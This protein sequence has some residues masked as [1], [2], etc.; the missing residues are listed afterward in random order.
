MSVITGLKNIDYQ[1]FVVV[2]ILDALGIDIDTEDGHLY[3]SEDPTISIDIGGKILRVDVGKA[4]KN[5]DYAIF[6]PLYREDHAQFLM[7]LAIYSQV[8]EDLLDPDEAGAD[9]FN[10]NTDMVFPV[11]DGQTVMIPHTLAKVAKGDGSE[12]FGEAMHKEETFAI[13]LAILE[14]AYKTKL[15]SSEQATKLKSEIDQAYQDYLVTSEMKASQRRKSIKEKEALLQ[16]EV[17]YDDQMFY[18]DDLTPEDEIN[19]EKEELYFDNN[20]EEYRMPAMTDSDFTDTQPVDKESDVFEEDFTDD[21]LIELFGIFG[22][23]PP[24]PE[25]QIDEITVD[26]PVQPAK[27]FDDIQFSEEVSDAPIYPVG[28]T[29]AENFYDPM[30][31]YGCPVTNQNYPI[32]NPIPPAEVE[33]SANPMPD[34]QLSDIVSKEDMEAINKRNEVT[35]STPEDFINHS[36]YNMNMMGS[37]GFGNTYGYDNGGFVPYIPS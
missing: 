7:T 36:D 12:I 21:E 23:T 6:N 15:I 20:Y 8:M 13:V 26:S 1:K 30:M 17:E 22:C 9:S 28:A 35:P 25:V 24:A 18:D 2:E 11:E 37:S 3:Y 34:I 4:R 33:S 16:P 19:R 32:G 27:S 31:G 5:L 14:Y 29:P 10:I